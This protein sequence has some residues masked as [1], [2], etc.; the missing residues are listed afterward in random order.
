MDKPTTPYAPGMSRI[1]GL[2][3]VRKVGE[4]R[5]NMGRKYLA[6]VVATLWPG[7]GDDDPERTAVGWV[8]ERRQQ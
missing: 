2:A 5:P 1:G 4:L 7:H 6:T 3:F 8:A